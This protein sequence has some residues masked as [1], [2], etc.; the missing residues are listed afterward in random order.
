MATNIRNLVTKVKT[1]VVMA[2]ILGAIHALADMQTR[3]QEFLLG[4]M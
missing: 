2:P 1:L 4:E 3:I